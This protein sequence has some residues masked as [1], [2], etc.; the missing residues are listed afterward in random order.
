MSLNTGNS[1]PLETSSKAL[2]DFVVLPK[3]TPNGGEKFPDLAR[4][5]FERQ[6]RQADI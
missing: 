1:M 6:H 5:S 3:L 4:P 2:D